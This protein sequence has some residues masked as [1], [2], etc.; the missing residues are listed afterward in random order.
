MDT[1]TPAGAVQTFYKLA[2]AHRYSEAWALADPT[3]RSQLDGYASF[4]AGQAA[5][6]S[7]TFGEARVTGQRSGV[8]TVEVQTTSV[9]TTGTEHCA[10]TVEVVSG[11]QSAAWLLHR[12]SIN[13]A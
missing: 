7:I 13:C 5:D 8:T 12:I 10:G 11:G 4:Q 1:S 3:F 6:R 9:R 2:A